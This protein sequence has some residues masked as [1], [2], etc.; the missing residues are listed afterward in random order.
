MSTLRN[1][2][3]SLR[4]MITDKDN[5]SDNYDYHNDIVADK[6][7]HSKCKANFEW[8]GSFISTSVCF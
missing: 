7:Q 1:I 4:S 3:R 6:E 8:A 5:D 2:N